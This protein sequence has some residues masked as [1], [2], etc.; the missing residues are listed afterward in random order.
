MLHC[1]SSTPPTSENFRR[2][3]QVAAKEEPRAVKVASDDAAKTALNTFVDGH[4]ELL[5]ELAKR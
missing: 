1:M 5:G 2:A 3:A 4:K